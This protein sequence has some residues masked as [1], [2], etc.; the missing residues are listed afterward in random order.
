MMTLPP[1]SVQMWVER[2]HRHI[3]SN[4]TGS[5]AQMVKQLAGELA[6]VP[7]IPHGVRT[8]PHIDR[9]LCALF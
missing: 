9:L 3:G 6:P 4:S 8:P 1:Q 2:D 7:R 5:S